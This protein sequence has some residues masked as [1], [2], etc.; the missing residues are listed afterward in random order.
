[1][2]RSLVGLRS[3]ADFEYNSGHPF[4]LLSGEPTN[5]DNH[6]PMGGRS[7]RLAIRVWGRIMR[8]STRAEL[9]SQSGGES[10]LLITAEGFN[11]ANRTNYASVNNQVGRC[12][13]FVEFNRRYVHRRLWRGGFD[14]VQ[15]A[16]DRAWI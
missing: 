1:M 12:S 7:E 15:R 4:N 16:W 14:D 8:I 6:R 13:G 9:A 11:I 10:T 5:G 2:E 3:G